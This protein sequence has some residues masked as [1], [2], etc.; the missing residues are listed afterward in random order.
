MKLFILSLLRHWSLFITWLCVPRP[1]WQEVAAVS[2]P[3]DKHSASATSSLCSL[4]RNIL[5]HPD[6]GSQVPPAQPS[7]P[8]RLPGCLQPFIQLCNPQ[9]AAVPPSP[10][11]HPD[12]SSSQTQSFWSTLE[13]RT[14]PGANTSCAVAAGTRRA[15]HLSPRSA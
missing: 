8:S 6:L 10:A 1:G 11:G 12:P 2:L 15:L 4:F 3:F 7:F 13:V 14:S 5:C 9:A